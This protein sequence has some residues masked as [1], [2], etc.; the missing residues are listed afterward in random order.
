M[1][2]NIAVKQRKGREGGRGASH[3][4]NLK[5]NNKIKE[6]LEWDG[7]NINNNQE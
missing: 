6:L 2:V 1:G 7:P 3:M 5:F 4:G